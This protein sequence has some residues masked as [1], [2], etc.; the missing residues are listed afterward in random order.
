MAG[1]RIRCGAERFVAGRLSGAGLRRIAHLR[2]AKRAANR[3]E[4][5]QKRQCEYRSRS[6]GRQFL[7]RKTHA[8]R[9]RH[10][11]KCVNA[12]HNARVKK[13]LAV[14]G[15]DGGSPTRDLG[16]RS[17]SLYASE[18]RPRIGSIFIIAAKR[19]AIAAHCPALPALAVRFL[20]YDRMVLSDSPPQFRPSFENRADQLSLRTGPATR[21]SS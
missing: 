13:V 1:R 3:R 14:N 7:W 16:V 4:E 15:G 10:A 12:S 20:F 9:L 17:A 18:L 2:L 19:R 11:A 5:Q 21:R 6:S 8:N